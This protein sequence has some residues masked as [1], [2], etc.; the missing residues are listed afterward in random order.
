LTSSED[1]LIAAARLSH[2]L[3][4]GWR[5]PALQTG[6][7]ALAAGEQVY[8]RARVERWEYYAQSVK[9]N[10]GFLLLFGGFF[11]FAYSLIGSL[12]FHQW[13]KGK[14]QSEAMT[15]WRPIDA[16]TLY[17]TNYRLAIMGQQGWLDIPYPAIRASECDG[18][19]IV[20]RLDQYQP[21][22]L[23][24]GLPEC[25][26]ALFRFLAYGEISRLPSAVPLRLGDGSVL[27]G[28]PDFALESVPLPPLPK[29]DKRSLP[30]GIRRRREWA[31]RIDLVAIAVLVA[32]LGGGQSFAGFLLL[33]LPISAVYF[34]GSWTL[35]G[36]TLGMKFYPGAKL[37]VVSDDDGGKPS[38]AA[39]IRRYLMMLASMLFPVEYLLS[40]VNP[41]YRY[42]HDRVAKTSVVTIDQAE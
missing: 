8:A 27:Q 28:P 7:V 9:Y 23:R 11:S 33:A 35:W 32:A 21:I 17:I 4:Q 15:Q 18:T 36:R 12:I 31:F 10:S 29:P 5:P 40:F 6:E 19:G 13:Q 25:L 37:R 39:S 3:Q 22:K 14:A 26:F 16:G 2:A 38:L 20:V 1:G 42:L 41:H 34:I 24:V 30:Q